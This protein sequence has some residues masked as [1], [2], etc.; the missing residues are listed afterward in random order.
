MAPR[1]KPIE[2]RRRRAAVLALAVAALVLL[3]SVWLASQA[4]FF[5]GTDDKGFVTVF[6]GVPYELPAGVQLYRTRY[7][8]FVPAADLRGP[9]RSAVLDHD[10]RARSDAFALIRR[11]ERRAQRAPDR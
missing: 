4:V 9:D 2:A 5:V 7:V 3:V 10:W 8:S 1:R 11:I 6:Q